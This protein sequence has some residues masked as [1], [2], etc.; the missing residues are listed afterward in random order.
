MKYLR[1]RNKLLIFS[2][3]PALVAVGL[4]LY[5]KSITAAAFE[6]RKLSFYKL[7]SALEN[8][9]ADVAVYYKDL[10]DGFEY[11]YNP[12]KVY[13]SASLVKI[14]VMAA[15]FCAVNEGRLPPDLLVKYQRRHRAGGAGSLRRARPG[16][17]FSIGELNY[18]M[19]VESDNVAT[20]MLCDILGLGYINEKMIGWGLNVTD[21]KRWVMDLGRRNAGLEN[22]TTAR[23]MGWFLERIYKGEIVSKEACNQMISVMKRQKHRNRLAR[24]L[25]T[26]TPVANKTGL[27]R[28]V[29]HDAG[30]IFT[31]KGD[32]V[33]C[34]L[35][36]DIPS[37]PAKRLIG[38]ISYIVYD[39][40]KNKK[41][42]RLTKLIQ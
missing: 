42:G 36:H 24:Y 1:K 6:E 41:D 2:F 8:L 21:M 16:K 20:N 32:Y 33:L 11:T 27:M 22:N 25:P 10:S 5:L 18:R 15:L 38:E 9:K 23:E 26:E 37:S 7:Q 39:I 34:V 29:V 28:D 4:T 12:D 30:I 31:E 35:T 17:K 14:P 13:P 3:V 40:Q 19:I